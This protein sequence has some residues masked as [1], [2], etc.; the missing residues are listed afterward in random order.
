MRAQLSSYVIDTIKHKE[1]IVNATVP[2]VFTSVRIMFWASFLKTTTATSA[3][4]CTASFFL[5]QPISYHLQ[6]YV[7]K[8][9]FG[10]AAVT[11]PSLMATNHTWPNIFSANV[12]N[13]QGAVMTW[14]LNIG[15]LMVI[16]Y[17]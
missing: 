6:M 4:Y 15:K 17:Q 14:M 13:S 2:D 8:K 7:V 12:Y 5:S 10:V 9:K 3:A 1:C 11:A 16:N